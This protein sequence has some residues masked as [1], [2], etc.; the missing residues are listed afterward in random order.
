MSR[1]DLEDRELS[2]LLGDLPSY[3]LTQLKHGLY[4]EFQE[5]EDLTVFPK[6]LRA[7]LRAEDELK[8]SL[9]LVSE[10]VADRGETRKWL[11]RLH[12]DASIE[13]V[14]MHYRHHT[15][16]CISSQAGCAMAC[17][18]C[19]TGH[20]GYTRQLSTGE[21]IEQVI[22]AARSARADGRRLD[23]VV[24][25]GMGE[26]FANFERV[27]RSVERIVDDIGLGARHITLST[28]GLVPQIRLL[29]D[30]PLQVNLAV[31][32]HAANDELRSRLVPINRRYP[33]R[34]LI[35]SL[36]EYFAK[37]HRRI[38]FE[39]AL[40]AGVNDTAKDIAEL[41]AIAFPLYAHVNLIPLNPIR[42]DE[43]T[44]MTGSSPERVT[45]FA[46]GL[47]EL[48]IN[49]TVR[50]TRGRSIDA[51]CGQLASTNRV[52]LNPTN[53]Q[54]SEGPDRAPFR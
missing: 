38:S 16:V 33:I 9:E 18:F 48:G 51:A 30:R 19:A 22:F 15:T 3:R 11:F 41:A 43:P 27:W 7:R 37:T 44:S 34:M 17:T 25:M 42:T 13:T 10:Q 52:T 45:A 46:E 36:E 21:I 39:W 2:R 4:E 20:G 6:S 26:P 14:L 28:V 5:I 1:Y 32:L 50:Q 47:R 49:A 54:R 24:Y 12:D 29:A 53:A 23:H 40:I 31:S 8:H 35:E